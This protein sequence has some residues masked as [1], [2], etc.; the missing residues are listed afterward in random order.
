MF[1]WQLDPSTHACINPSDNFIGM[2]LYSETC[3]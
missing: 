2:I 3:L 1:V